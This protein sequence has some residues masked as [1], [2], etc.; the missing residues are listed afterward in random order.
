MSKLIYPIYNIHTKNFQH[1]TMLAL[2]HTLCDDMHKD[3]QILSHPA[4]T[5]PNHS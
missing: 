5:A 4:N 1:L 3:R 2:P